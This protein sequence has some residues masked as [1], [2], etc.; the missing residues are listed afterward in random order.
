MAVCIINGER[1]QVAAGATVAELLADLGLQEKKIA[2]EKNGDIVPKS[3]H[4]SETVAPGD[5]LEI[6]A[7]VGGG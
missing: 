2:V 1:R 3:R 4:S 6:V 5:S 7:A